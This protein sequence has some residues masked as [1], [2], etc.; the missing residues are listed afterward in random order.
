MT[1]VGIVGAGGMGNVHANHYGKMPDVEL[2]VF[3]V[4]GEKLSAFADRHSAKPLG[5]FDQLASWADVVDVCVPTDRHCEIALK[6]IAAGRATF[7][8]KPMGLTVEECAT[9]MD[10]AS[11]AAVPLMP[12]HVLR[13]FAEYEA[14]HDAVANGS[15]GTP[16]AARTRRG[17]KAPMGHG[18][19]FRDPARSGGVTLDLAIHDFDWLRWTLGEVER[20]YSQSVSA[21]RPDLPGADYSL[22]TLTFE[23]GAVA[24]VEATWMDPGGFRTTFEVCGSEGMIEYDSRSN[25]ALRTH[26][27]SGSVLEGAL[28]G[29]D[30]PYY[31]QLGGFLQAV[32]DGTT[33]PI[34]PADGFMAVSIARAAIESAHTGRVVRPA[35][36]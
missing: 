2:A 11:R 29:S 24:H 8:E 17:G 5:T 7:V 10:A 4:D 25:A 18:G 23:S 32:R 14:G 35:R 12:G 31:R 1:R 19:W 33:P 21:R 22:T 28:L 26:T 30:D 20:V 6:A 36:P 34:S 15:V 27:E 16:S 9:M 13:F 3:D